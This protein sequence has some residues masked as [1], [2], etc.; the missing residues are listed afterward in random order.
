MHVATCTDC[1]R[2][3]SH[4]YLLFMDAC[5]CACKQAEL[6]ICI[7]YS[8][9]YTTFNVIDSGGPCIEWSC[10]IWC[11]SGVGYQRW[12][13]MWWHPL[14]DPLLRLICAEIVPGRHL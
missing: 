12:E 10:S 11:N 8:R 5:M 6:I 14:Y 3:D 13:H 9:P 2:G 1:M 7:V 4:M